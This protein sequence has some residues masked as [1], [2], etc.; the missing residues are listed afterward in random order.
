MANHS[1]RPKAPEAAPRPRRE[2]PLRAQ[3]RRRP[4]LPSARYTL[5]F[6]AVLGGVLC[7]L[8]LVSVLGPESA[9]TLG[10]LLAPCAA[11]VSVR[12]GLAS[13]GR[14]STN[15]LVEAVGLSWLL[16]L[17]PLALLCLNAL[18]GQV[19]DPY[20]GL[21]F[22]A[23]GPWPSVTLAAIVGVAASLVQRRK[24]ATTVALT[25]PAACVARALFD[26]VDT[27]GIFAFGHLFG[28]F[29]GTLYDRQVDVPAAWLSHRLLT[30]I[31]GAG[32]WAFI[33]A[34]RDR[35]TGQLRFRRLEAHPI[36]ACAVVV[37]SVATLLM[38]Q[39]SDSLG[40]STSSRHV[41]SALGLA[42]EGPRC[43]VLVPRELDRAEAQRLAEECELRISQLERTLG[44]RETE[45][46]TAYFFRSPQEKRTLMGAARVYIAKP[47]R[48]EAYLQLAGFPHPVL[49]HELAHVVA[50]HIARGPFGVPGK[51][52]G[53]IPEPT[54]V[55]GL[56]V[57][58]D[59]TSRDE[60]T[61]HEWA[62]AA[63]MAKVAPPLRALLGPRFLSQNQALAYTLAGSFLRYVLDTYG[64]A[65]VRAVYRS[66]DVTGSLGKSFRELE[67]AWESA[68]DKL[69]LPPQAAALAK[70][71]FERPG[72]F[73]QV[74]PHQIERLENELGAALAAGDLVRA[75]QRCND[76][77]RI[78]PGNSG[79]R[80][81]YAGTLAQADKSR[82]AEAQLRRLQGPP[83]APTPTI[84][85][86]RTLVADA[87]YMKGDH[88]GALRAYQELLLLPQSESE[89]RQLEVKLLA[90]E[91]GE[92]AR[93]LVGELLIGRNGR[94]P[95]QRVAMHLIHRL[96]PTRRDGLAVYLEARQLLFAGRHDL[97]RPLLE[98]AFQRGLPTR[99]L[100]LE[101]HRA[102]SVA[103]FVVGALDDAL[104]HAR[105]I[106][107]G[108]EASL[109]EQLES[110]DFEQRVL[111]R[112]E[113][114]RS[115]R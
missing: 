92:P 83:S 26:F 56:A 23:L 60:L 35:R 57:A 111:F 107:E 95:D 17:I 114:L 74:C 72:V 37:L 29:P 21:A 105:A 12:M 19:C 10:L 64:A 84:A 67:A 71:R 53:L 106:P 80:A 44:V 14:S 28:Y 24:L 75:Q 8:P 43:R 59:P 62:K 88:A 103:C 110:A 27:P 87:S 86:A 38:A 54:L 61:P 91:A 46:I 93:S 32:L 52:K 108:A 101:A 115:R 49:A 104:D 5:L 18:R 1:S 77:L 45:R 22:M 100:R 82:E 9:L 96:A 34:I 109:A 42:V 68:L 48:R 6:S 15:L 3:R 89:L 25:V 51:L 47:W 11:V 36:A 94:A 102:A 41:A 20:D 113:Q 85:R 90:L 16:L 70:L 2:G 50:R 78:D 33:A 66:G 98:A 39:R 30:V 79:T 73:S 40:H 97:A 65:K 7:F 58:V 76:V 112:R 69:P 55:E 63:K 4:L 13:Q 81:T 31:V 99:R